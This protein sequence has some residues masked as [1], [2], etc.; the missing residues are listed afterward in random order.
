MSPAVSIVVATY[1]YGRFLAGAL[2]STLAQ[3]Y[4]NFETIIVDDGSEDETEAVAKT[5]LSDPRIRYHRTPRQGQPKAKNTGI[6]LSTAPLVA[7]LDADDLWLP[8]KLEK[9]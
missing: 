5:F 1:N 7:F 6:R 8:T 4:T 2:Q 3:T 9:Q